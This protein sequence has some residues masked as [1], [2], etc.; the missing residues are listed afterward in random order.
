MPPA[1]PAPVAI[2][3]L[4]LA[5]DGSPAARQSYVRLPP[6]EQPYVLRF[7]I[8]AGGLACRQGVLHTSLPLPGQP[9][10]RSTFRPVPLPTDVTKP[11]VVDLWV[12]APGVY[13][14]YVEHA[15]PVDRMPYPQHDA[16]LFPFAS[17]RSQSKHGYFNVD[18]LISLP[19]RSPVVS[20]DGQLLD[21]RLEPG[22]PPVRLSQDAIVMQTFVSKWAGTLTEWAPH[23]SLARDA[24]FN[25]IHF[26]PLQVRGASNSPYALADPHDFSPDLF[27]DDDDNS[28]PH[29]T[30]DQ[31]FATVSAWLNKLR[32]DWGIASLTDIVLNHVAHTSPWLYDH[33]ELGTSHRPAPACI[34]CSPLLALAL[35]LTLRRAIAL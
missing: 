13:E 30:R 35:A 4:K 14:F 34:A 1:D 17:A 32:S 20:P 33:P 10:R 23:L 31:R 6:P 5:S 15:A 28:M 29:A 24:G 12:H 16:A 18:P 27:G 22:A 11:I 19:A 8:Q 25:M 26:V 7:S 2:Y 21:P 9:F 3:E